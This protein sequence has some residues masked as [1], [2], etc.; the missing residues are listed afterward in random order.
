M[1]FHHPD[2]ESASNW[3]SR[4]GKFISTSQKHLPIV[5][6]IISLESLQYIFLHF[7]H[8]ESLQGFECAALLRNQNQ[9]SFFRYYFFL[10]PSTILKVVREEL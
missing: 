7:N 3:S 5:V 6:N 2:L 9:N 8:Q 1:T 4:V 10:R